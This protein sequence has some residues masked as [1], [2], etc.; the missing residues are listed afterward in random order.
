MPVR[1]AISSV[2]ARIPISFESRVSREALVRDAIEQALFENERWDVKTQDRVL[3]SHPGDPFAFLKSAFDTASVY[4]DQ[5]GLVRFRDSDFAIRDL[6]EASLKDR[7]L[8]GLARVLEFATGGWATIGGNRG[9]LVARDIPAEQLWMAQDAAVLKSKTDPHAAGVVKNLQFYT[10]GPGVKW[11]SP[12]EE[13]TRWLEVFRRDND[14]DRRERSMV[15]E[16]WQEGEYF[17]VFFVDP[18]TGRVKVRKHRP[19]DV[20]EIETSNED[21]E[22]RLS[23]RLEV[24]PLTHK[25][26]SEWIPDINYWLQKEDPL[27]SFSSAYEKEF[28]GGGQS[29][30][31][32]F[33]RYGDQDELRGWPPMY[34]SLRWFK[35]LE[36]FIIDRARLHHERAKVVWFQSR[37]GGSGR[38]RLGDAANANPHLAPKGGTMWIEDE[39]TSYRNV[40]LNLESGDASTDALLFLYAISSNNCMP[41]HVWNQRADQAV[42]SSLRK[43]DTPFSQGI[44]FNQAFL[45]SEW[46][47]RDRF[48]LR[49]AIQAGKLPPEVSIIQHDQNQVMKALGKI[50]EMVADGQSEEEIIKEAKS[51]LA[52]GIVRRKVSTLEVP[53]TRIF[54]DVVQESPLELAKVLLIHQ[55]MGLASDASLARRSGYN[56]TEELTGMF[57]EADMKKKLKLMRGE[58]APAQG[59]PG[60]KPGAGAGGTKVS[61]DDLSIGDA[62]DGAEPE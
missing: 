3:T 48:V 9:I 51:I 1:N 52:P 50:N 59:G 37:K 15:K 41:I 46:E 34:A 61:R 60:R 17:W 12:S 5:A 57:Q 49:L 7:A 33:S 53:I 35:Y 62:P 28:V 31:I 55:K 29:R 11:S 45:D 27:S 54:P 25:D 24:D 36:D 40:A 32:Q 26:S 20:P 56:W 10:V 18:N 39:T 30:F 22:T 58:T 42:Y 2:L 21:L 43:A 6:K 13:V 44:R 47:T 14:M 16:I 4:D 38:K 8:Q 19:K 23:Y